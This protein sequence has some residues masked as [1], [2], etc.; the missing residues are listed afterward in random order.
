MKE[1]KKG[2]EKENR[3][4]VLNRDIRMWEERRNEKMLR[5]TERNRRRQVG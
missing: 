5:R 3:K 1:G 2:M 4:K